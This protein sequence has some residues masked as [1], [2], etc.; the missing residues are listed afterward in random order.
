MPFVSAIV[1]AAGES[2]R[3]RTQKALLQWEGLPL[4]EYHLKQ[5]SDVEAIQQITVVTGHQPDEITKITQRFPRA[6]IAHNPEYR[7][8]K[9]SSI[10]TG[11][12]GLSPEADAILLIAVDQPRPADTLRALVTAHTK[13]R[14]PI[15]V[16]THDHHRGHPIIFARA[17]LPELLAI[18]EDTMGIRAVM[19][20]HRPDTRELPIDDAI[21]LLD[22]N[23]PSDMKNDPASQ[24][25]LR[26][27]EGAGD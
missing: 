16:P 17:L 18:T 6:Q 9:V 24:A 11:L 12:H 14:A 5:L 22:L 19:D 27:R 3:M 20:R 8:G 1:L 2:T 10:L 13:S 15:T 25:P 26:F 21:V 7:T 23:T 4:I